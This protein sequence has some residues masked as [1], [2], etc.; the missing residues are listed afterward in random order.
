LDSRVNKSS[1]CWNWKGFIAP[2]GYGRIKFK[3][4]QSNA[5]RFAWIAY[6]GE[7]PE[8]LFVCHHCDNKKCCNPEHL[9]LGAHQDNMDDGKAKKR[10]RSL[11]GE[12][13]GMHTLTN[14]D[15]WY[16]RAKR[17]KG[18]RQVRIAAVLGIHSGTVSR[19]LNGK[20]WAHL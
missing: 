20:R 18:W 6:N 1:G 14:D 13:H 15:I 3:G 19:I 2:N 11:A 9:F 7:I 12:A 8:G 4:Q 5:H 10:F 16:I 17:A